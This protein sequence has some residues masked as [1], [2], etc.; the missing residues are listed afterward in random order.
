MSTIVEVNPF[1]CRM[2]AMHDRLEDYLTE[3]SC[4]AELESVSKHGQLV[5]ALGRRVHNN[6][7]CDVELVV[8]SRRLFVAKLLNQPLKVELK[9]LTDQEALIAMDIENRHRQ[10]ISPYE[11]GLSYARMLR[12]GHFK[13]QDELAQALEIST[14]QVSRLMKLSRL[15]SVI[16]AAFERPMDICEGWGVDLMDLWDDPNMKPHIA[17]RAR[18]IAALSARPSAPEIYRS[19]ISMGPISRRR[20]ANRDE[21]VSDSEGSPLFRVRQQQK[22]VAVLLP[23]EQWSGSNLQAVTSA[24]GELLEREKSRRQPVKERKSASAPQAFLS[25]NA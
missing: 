16:V 23:R 10:D 4:Q 15:P 21:V 18:A 19:L 1:R 20:S 2:W 7:D 3:E 8:G 25:A 5:P 6:P 12:A 9:E 11:R 24:L 13:S 17:R 22:W 14:A